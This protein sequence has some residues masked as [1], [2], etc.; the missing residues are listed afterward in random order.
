ML[1]PIGKQGGCRT[2]QL[3]T[4]LS[5]LWASSEHSRLKNTFRVR[6]HTKARTMVTHLGISKTLHL[7][8]KQRPQLIQAS[9]TSRVHSRPG[10]KA[11]PDGSAG[12]RCC[13]PRAKHIWTNLR[14]ARS[15]EEASIKTTAPQAWAESLD[16][17]CTCS[18]ALCF[19]SEVAV[20]SGHAAA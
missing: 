10:Q 20:T 6:P 13:R 15:H 7:D 12:W 9:S 11:L 8:G 2:L 14:E 17:T 5:A 19:R 18:S 3:C 4:F 1:L 16:S